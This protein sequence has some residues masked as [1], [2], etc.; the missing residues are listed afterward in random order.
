MRAVILAGGKGRRLHPYTAVF[1][2]PLVPLGDRPILEIVVEQLKLSGFD[3][4]TFAVGH[5]A[6]LI[7]AYFGDGSRFG[8]RIEYSVETKPLGTAGPLSLLSDLD[9]DFLVMNGDILTD[10]DFRAMLRR[11]RASG[12]IG[13]VAVY[14]KRVDLSL[15][16]V[17][18][19]A[20]DEVSGYVEKPAFNYL[21][22]SG[23]YCFRPDVLGHLESG[24][25]CDLPELVLRL[26]RRGQ[27][28]RGYRFEGYWFDIGRPEDYEVALEEFSRGRL[29]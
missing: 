22:S 20:N 15:G 4:L 17:E 11:H 14:N 18:L 27:S 9:G 7:Q 25:Y 10:L 21:V 13:T 26:I 6:G 3:R 19:D 2:K 24:A 8:I 1:P 5:L 16:V 28:V 23:I 12:A 29:R